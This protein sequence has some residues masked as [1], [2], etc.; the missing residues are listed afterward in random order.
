MPSYTFID[1]SEKHVDKGK[2]GYEVL[3]VNYSAKGESKSKNIMSFANPSVYALI[4]TLKGGETIDVQFVKDDKY[5]NWATVE[6][7]GGVVQGTVENVK[8]GTSKA[9]PVARST[10][11][12]A[13][14]RAKKQVYIIKQ[15]CLAQAI[16]FTTQATDFTG[17]ASDMDAVKTL[18]Q[19]F[20][21]WVLDDG[22]ESE[23][24][25]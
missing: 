1:Y 12:T 21:D 20:V 15:S 6:V 24:Q 4:K 7:V 18:A 11:E 8:E 16:V 2:T 13:E 17:D 25:D 5:F 23:S 9:L 22:T 19:E 14:E 10:Y 3:T